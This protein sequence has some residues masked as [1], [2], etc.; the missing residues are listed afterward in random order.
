MLKDWSAN[1]KT[2]HAYEA[3]CANAIEQ[4]IACDSFITEWFPYSVVALGKQQIGGKS[5]HRQ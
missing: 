1:E 3:N 5:R 2:A 4:F